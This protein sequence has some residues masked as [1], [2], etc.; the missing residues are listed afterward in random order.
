LTRYPPTLPP[1]TV[2]ELTTQILEEY[3]SG[4]SVTSSATPLPQ[5]EFKEKRSDFDSIM[6]EFLG[7]YKVLG[8]KMVKTQKGTSGGMS[9][10]DAIRRELG[11]TKIS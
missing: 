8:K 4:D 7:G 1:S 10:L 5:K 2:V 11:R 9:E 6:D 3:N